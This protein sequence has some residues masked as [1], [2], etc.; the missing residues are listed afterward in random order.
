MFLIF[1][2]ETTGFPKNPNAPISDLDN[3]PRVVQLAW[4]IHDSQGRLVSNKDYIIYPDGFD[5]PYNA[6]QIH[7]ISTKK[8]K[9]EGKDL[10]VV[11][12]EFNE[13]VNN[14][15]VLIGHNIQFDLNITASE[16]HRLQ[17]ET[18][19]LKTKSLDT[20]LIS[21][22]V[23]K[24]PGGRGGGFKYPKLSELYTFLFKET[25]DEAHNATADVNATA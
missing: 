17:L 24:L 10:K 5:I 9:E 1:D 25:F 4:Q 11:L 8:A 20:Q 14:S 18:P 12:E 2:T 7:G 6:T 22:P 19:L 16:F 3:W 15:K 13:D 21:T 23:C